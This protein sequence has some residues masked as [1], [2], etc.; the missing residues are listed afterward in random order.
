MK[1]KPKKPRRGNNTWHKAFIAALAKTGNVTE[2][3]RLVDRL[4]RRMPYDLRK[5]DAV[6][7][8]EWDSALEEASDRMETE[9]RRRA[10][11]GVLEP[12]YQGGKKVGSIRRYSDTLLIFLL[13]GARPDKYRD[14]FDV[15]HSG[16]IELTPV[17]I[18]QAGRD[19]DARANGRIKAATPAL[20]PERNGRNGTH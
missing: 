16:G 2:A 1:R 10:E 8:A 3:C 6:F 4:D 20:P 17:H 9:A 5:Q 15:N 7:A 19:L 13:K 14:R 12:V 18:L 11:Q